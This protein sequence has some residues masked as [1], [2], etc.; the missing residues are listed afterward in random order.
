MK[1]EGCLND[2]SMYIEVISRYASNQYFQFNSP[3]GFLNI[4]FLHVFKEKQW[5]NFLTSYLIEF[6]VR[7]SKLFVSSLCVTF[8]M[9]DFLQQVTTFTNFTGY[10]IIL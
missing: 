1:P 5:S 10:A 8:L 9:T 3:T 7:P 4:Y 2:F 6:L